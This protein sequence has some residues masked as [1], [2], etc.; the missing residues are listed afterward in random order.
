MKKI[1]L[2]SLLFIV[3]LGAEAQ[4]RSV[5][6]LGDSYSTF[7]GFVQPAKN[8][9]WYKAEIVGAPDMVASFHHRQ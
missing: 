1:I 7:Q 9:I 5:A 8:R 4:R 2:F 6:I 3:C